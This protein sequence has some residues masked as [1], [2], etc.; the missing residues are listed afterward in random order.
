VDKLDQQIIAE[1]FAPEFEHIGNGSRTNLK[2][3]SEHLAEYMREYKGFRIPNWDELFSAGDKVVTS[4]T[5]EGETVTGKQD[6]SVGIA[7]WRLANGKVVSLREVDAR[8]ADVAQAGGKMA[9]QASR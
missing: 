4:Y 8:P 3:Y 1:Y 5:L 9:G 7:I 2:G 6:R